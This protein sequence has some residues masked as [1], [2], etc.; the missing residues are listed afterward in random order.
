VVIVGGGPGGSIAAALLAIKG[1]RVLLLEAESFPR[2][3]IG[4]SFVTGLIPA[5]EEAGV[6]LDL[7]DREFR[8]KTG[9]YLV[10]GNKDHDMWRTS[11][12]MAKVSHTHAW[13]IDRAHFDEILLDNAREH[14]ATVR[15][16]AKVVITLEKDG[17]VNGVVY[18]DESGEH[19]IVAPMTVDASGQSRAARDRQDYGLMV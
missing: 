19:E 12:S 13:H 9:L 11:F 18:V 10:W 5:L 7:I 16:N 1:R 8:P 15:E 3:H 4:E 14:G 6:D 2:Y 17:R